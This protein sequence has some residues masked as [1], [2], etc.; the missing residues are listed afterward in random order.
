MGLGARAG[1]SARALGHAALLIGALLAL[2]VSSA[3]CSGASP[4]APRSSPVAAPTAA[5]SAAPTPAPT[6]SPAVTLDEARHVLADLLAADDVARANGDERLALDLS[7]DAVH[8][9][10]AAVYHSAGMSPPRYVWHSP[11]VL[12]PRL[13]TYPYWFAATAERRYGRHGS[14]RTAVLVLMRESERD[15]WRIAFSSL[16]DKGQQP[17]EVRLDAEGYAT[18]LDTRDES[19]TISPHLMGPLHATIAEEGTG[20]FAAGL[21]A[22]GPHTT[23][24]FSQIQKT[25]RVAKDRDCMNYDSIFAA[26]T[27]PV[28]ALRTPSGGAVIMYSLLRTTSWTPVLKC[29]EGRHLPIPEGAEWLLDDP[30]VLKQRRII[31]TQQYVATVP[32]KNAAATAKVVGYT[33]WTT[34]ATA[35]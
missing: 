25:E 8:A 14:S 21:I 30:I 34:K 5:S 2:A 11:T 31:E 32:A 12:V 27:F 6:P 28:F 15:R 4:T 10:T 16:L 3:A 19:V 7:R 29:G 23:G 17:P 26:T 18:A 13:T 20:G 33:G 35:R 1:R 22:G 24:Y 9:T